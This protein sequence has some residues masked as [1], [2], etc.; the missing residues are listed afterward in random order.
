VGGTVPIDRIENPEE[1]VGKDAAE[2]R[3][4]IADRGY[5]CRAVHVDGCARFRFDPKHDYDPLRV[6]LWVA[7]GK[8][9]KAA[10]G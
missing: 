8:V 4:L 5:E 9:T 10:I 6:N 1:F 7:A 2:A 3:A